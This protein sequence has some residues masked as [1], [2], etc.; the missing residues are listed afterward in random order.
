MRRGRVGGVVASGGFCYGAG[1]M[2]TAYSMIDTSAALR[3]LVD[4]LQEEAVLAF[5]TEFTWERTYYARLGLVQV[6]AADGRCFLIDPLAAGDL[7]PLGELLANARIV[8]ILHD[9]PQDL[10]ILRRATGAAARNV[11]DTRQAAGFAG[12]GAALSLA[13]LLAETVGV[14]LAKAHTRADWLARP[15]AP[16]E[17]DYAADDVRYLPEVAE[18]LRGRARTA[19]VE[20]WLDEERATLDDPETTAEKPPEEAYLRIRAAANL[21]PRPLAALRELAAWREQAARASDLPRRWLLEDGELVAIASA[22]PQTPDGLKLKPPAVA[23]WGAEL[24]AAVRRAQEMP[25]ANLP[26]PISSRRAPLLSGKNS[27]PSWR[28]SRH[29]PRPAASIRRWSAAGTIWPGCFRPVRKPV[30]RITPC[31]AAGAPNSPALA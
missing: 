12:L 27:T 6:A 24:L 11:F 3:T 28:K 18:R 14:H 16:E 22:L 4:R 10:M 29:G 2:S 7:A 1:P 9:A 21:A 30:R 8:K 19:G 13:N 23:R 5:D 26:P 17:L 20:A 25:E 31:C 15:L